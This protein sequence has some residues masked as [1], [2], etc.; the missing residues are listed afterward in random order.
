MRYILRF[1]S[2]RARKLGEAI[3]GTV[4]CLFIL[5]LISLAILIGPLSLEYIVETWDTVLLGRNVDWPL[6]HPLALFVGALG[7]KIFVPL[8]LLTWV[9]SILGVV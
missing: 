1:R 3:G 9:M 5:G 7:A 2:N 4:G 6:W 8:A